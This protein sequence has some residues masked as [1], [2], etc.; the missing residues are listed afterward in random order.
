MFI[1][2]SKLQ[3][4]NHL[5]QSIQE[6]NDLKVYTYDDDLAKTANSHLSLDTSHI[7]NTQIASVTREISMKSP[8]LELN[9]EVIPTE[10]L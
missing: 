5:I 8:L 1:A 4:T 10:Y 6:S 3:S 2:A 9:T 7:M